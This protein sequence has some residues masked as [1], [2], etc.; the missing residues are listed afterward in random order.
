MQI[1]IAK[2]HSVSYNYYAMD[3]I[4]FEWDEDK[5]QLNIRNHGLD[6][7]TASYVFADPDRIEYY[8]EAHSTEEERYITVGLVGNL[9]MVVYTVRYPVSCLSHHICQNS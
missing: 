8:D 6:F 5:E 9:I 2:L 3:E 4:I 1:C 7:E